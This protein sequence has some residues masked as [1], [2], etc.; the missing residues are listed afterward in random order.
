MKLPGDIQ[1]IALFRALQ[2][3]D[4]LCTI[5]AARA[6][7]H[8][9]PTAQITLLGLPWSQTLVARFPHYFDDFVHFPGFP[10]L[11]EQPFEAEQTVA[12]LQAMQQRRFDLLLQMQ[13]NGNLTNPLLL[14][15]GA[16]HVA[17]FYREDNFCPNGDYFTPYLESGSEIHR[18]LRLM[19]FLGIPAQGDALEFPL[20]AADAAAYA[21]L[22]LPVERGAYIVLHPGARAEQRR[23]SPA[24]FAQLGDWCAQAGYPVVLT[25]V[26]AERPLTAAVKAAMQAPVIDTTGQTTLGTLGVLVQEARLVI[27]NDTG[28][29]HLAAALQTPSVV[30]ACV[31]DERWRP[32]NQA[33]HRWVPVAA[34]TGI[35]P[36][37][38]AVRE[39]LV[40]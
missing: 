21:Q 28:I 32:L 33:L 15:L 8:A 6:L 19:T 5:P 36:V 39:Q 30:V 23:W 34:E 7:R 2:L 4:W 11:P 40:R 37:L 29:S 16:R 20:T 24:F 12:F 38:T 31:P 26:E 3:G 17:G 9:L 1:R 25:G 10:G 27:C 35:T 18:F 22:A 14:L 13:G